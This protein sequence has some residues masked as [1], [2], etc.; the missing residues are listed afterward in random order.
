MGKGLIEIVAEEKREHA[1]DRVEID[2]L[3]EKYIELVKETKKTITV[4]CGDRILKIEE[5]AGK[6]YIRVYKLHSIISVK[7]NEI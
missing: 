7:E 3:L 2:E 1:G 4:E 6:I 5:C